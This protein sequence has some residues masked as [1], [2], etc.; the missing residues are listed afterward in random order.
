ME[1]AS[2]LTP[3][4]TVPDAEDAHTIG[5]KSAR[6]PRVELITRGERRRSWTPEQK[7][8]IVAESLGPYLTPTE[9]ARKYAISSGQLYTWRGQV[10]GGPGSRLARSTPSF[11]RVEIA[12]TLQQL[13]APDATPGQP[14]ASFEL[15]VLSRPDGLIEIVLP[16]GLTLRVDAGVDG[17]ALRRV[18]D[19]VTAR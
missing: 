17:P 11:A 5:L 14:A 7:R 12:P 2:P 4:S 15:A 3:P 1:T 16:G 9:V 13:E 18:L 19:A 6:S 10:L 8:E